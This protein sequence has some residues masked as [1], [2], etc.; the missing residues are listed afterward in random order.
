[1]NLKFK[2]TSHATASTPHR[3]RLST[4]CRGLR[5]FSF[6]RFVDRSCEGTLKFVVVYFLFHGQAVVKATTFI[7]RFLELVELLHQ[8]TDKPLA[9]RS[10]NIVFS[11]F[12]ISLARLDKLSHSNV[13][14][15]PSKKTKKVSG[16][17]IYEHLA[18]ALV[19]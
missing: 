10:V 9:L 1:M 5:P 2:L 14:F 17:R 13:A 6:L 7:S 3:S 8:L 18:N 12:N 15:F 11:L 19:L 16:V 4:S